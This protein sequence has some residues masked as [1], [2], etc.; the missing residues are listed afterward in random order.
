MNTD[1]EIENIYKL[2]NNRFLVE[3]SNGQYIVDKNY[4]KI[5]HL[6]DYQ[7]IFTTSDAIMLQDTSKGY[8]YVC[9]LDG[10]VVKKYYNREITNTHDDKYYMV[11]TE[12]TKN[13]QKYTEYYLERLGVRQSTPLASIAED[14]ARYTYN[15]TEYVG[16]NTEM[17]KNGVSIITRIKENGSTYDYQLFNVDGEL[18]LELGGFTTTTQ[19]LTLKYSDD[20]QMIL[21]IASNKGGI[22]YTI[23]VDR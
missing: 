22:G 3:N 9:S 18:L 15:E 1:Y 7:N 13:D 6:G 14:S 5:C 8:T 19:N 16:F 21:Y 11:S 20:N 10:V 2:N 4:K 23:L 17:F 12:V